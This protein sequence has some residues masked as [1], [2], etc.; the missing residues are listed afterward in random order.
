M[1]NVELE[2]RIVTGISA[3]LPP[4]LSLTSISLIPG[5]SEDSPVGI[6]TCPD[7]EPAESKT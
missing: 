4:V 5:K 1:V 7:H 3:S 6:V 2:S